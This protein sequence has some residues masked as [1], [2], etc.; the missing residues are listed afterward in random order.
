MLYQVKFNS[1]IAKN[2][3]KAFK[4]IHS[5]KVYHGDARPENILVKSDNSVV[6]VDFEMSIIDADQDMLMREMKKVK[7]ILAGLK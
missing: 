7:S 2:V 3:L 6:I 5:R 1:T 4:E